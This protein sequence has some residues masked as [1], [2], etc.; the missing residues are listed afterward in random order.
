[1]IIRLSQLRLNLDD[2]Q[3]PLGQ[4]AARALKARPEDSVSVRL[5][6]KSVDARD[7]ADVHFV[8]TLEVR[9]ARPL[10]L[11]RGAEALGSPAE[12]GFGVPAI[13]CRAAL[14]RRPLVV[15]MGPA[16]LFAALA[17][18]RAGLRPMVIERGKRVE[19]RERDVSAFFAGGDDLFAQ[20][21]HQVLQ[22]GGAHVRPGLPQG[23]LGRA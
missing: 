21:A 3:L 5:L 13:P 23:V 16:G 6:R 9:T 4:I 1:M 19:E 8:L 14:S 17:L 22:M 12:T 18:A 15:G 20:R 10:R 7:R 2:W 11:P